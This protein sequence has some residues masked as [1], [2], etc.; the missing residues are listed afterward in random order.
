M[1]RTLTSL[2]RAQRRAAG[3]HGRIDVPL[4]SGRRLSALTASGHRATEIER[5]GTFQR[6]LLAAERLA[7]IGAPQSVLQVPQAHMALAAEAMRQ[8]GVAGTV[9][10]MGG[11]R[12]IRV[13]APGSAI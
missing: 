2:R 13:R 5:S 4:P 3:K 9:R 10:N 7:E 6:L 11:T 8:V 12:R 1:S